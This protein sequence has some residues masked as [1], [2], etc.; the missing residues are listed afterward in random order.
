MAILGQLPTVNGL[1]ERPPRRELLGLDGKPLLKESG[2]FLLPP[3][4][5]FAAIY[6]SLSRTYWDLFEDSLRDSRQNA[7]AMRRDSFVRACL[8][9]RYLQLV[10]LSHHLESEDQKSRVQKPVT[11]ELSKI[12]G[13]TRRWRHFLWQLAEAIWFGRTGNQLKWG[14]LAI[15]GTQRLCVVDHRPVGESKINFDYDGTP[16]IRLHYQAFSELGLED[17]AKSKDLQI[18]NRS[19]VIKLRDPL[20]RDRFVI[21]KHTPEDPDF[22]EGEFAGQVHGLGLRGLCYWSLYLRDEMLG[23]AVNHLKKIGVG[24][25]LCFFYDESNDE[26]RAKAEAAAQDAGENFAI[27]MPRPRG[28]SKETAS[29][30][31]F[32]FSEAG[33]Q[34]LINVVSDYFERHVERLIIGQELSSKAESTGLGSGVATMQADTK[35]RILK[36]D[37]E[38]L[39]DCLTWEYVKVAQK[40]NFPNANWMTKFVF[41]VPDPQAGE[42][43]KAAGIAFQTGAEIKS[44]ELLAAAGFSRAEEDDDTLS[45]IKLL[46]AT[47]EIQMKAQLALA[48]AQGQMQM[49]QAQEAQASGLAPQPM[50]QQGA[51]PGAQQGE[52][53]GQEQGQP[54]EIPQGQEE[55]PQGEQKIPTGADVLAAIMEPEEENELILADG[56]SLPLDEDDEDSEEQ[57][58]GPQQMSTHGKSVTYAATHS[59]SGGT[60]IAGTFYPGGQYIPNAVL[61]KATPQEKAALAGKKAMTG[62]KVP[63]MPAHKPMHEIAEKR[64]QEAKPEPS[65]EVSPTAPESTQGADVYVPSVNSPVMA[66]HEFESIQGSDRWQR[67]NDQV[68][69]AV[70][71]L[72]EHYGNLPPKG[73]NSWYV[74][75][76]KAYQA[77]REVGI[78]V[79]DLGELATNDPKVL[80]AQ[81]FYVMDGYMGQRSRTLRDKAQKRDIS[82]LA[83]DSSKFLAKHA[84]KWINNPQAAR[85]ALA[86]S[87]F[88]GTP[89]LDNVV[90]PALGVNSQ[91]Q[92]SAKKDLAI[93]ASLATQEMISTAVKAAIESIPGIIKIFANRGVKTLQD[94]ELVF[95]YEGEENHSDLEIV[96]QILADSMYERLMA[97][98]VANHEAARIA[99][100]H[101]SRCAP[102]VLQMAMQKIEEENQGLTPEQILAH[103]RQVAIGVTGDAVVHHLKNGLPNDDMGGARHVALWMRDR[104]KNRLRRAGLGLSEVDL[105]EIASDE[106]MRLAPQIA[107]AV[108]V[109]TSIGYQGEFDESKH[110]RDHGKFATAIAHIAGASGSGKTTL[111]N[112]LQ[113][114]HKNIHV[115][116]LDDF[117][118]EASEHLYPGVPKKKY[119]DEM[120]NTLAGQRQ[121]MLDDFMANSDKPVVL[122]GH[123]TEGKHQLH[124]PAESKYLLDVDAK[125]S[126]MR[127]FKRSQTEKPE[128]RRKMSEL[129]LDEKEAQQDIDFL[130]K[131]GYKRMSPQ[132]IEDAISKHPSVSGESQ[133][134]SSINFQ[135]AEYLP[136]HAPCYLELG[137]VEYQAGE[138]IPAEAVERIIEGERKWLASLK[139]EA[140][141]KPEIKPV[142]LN[143]PV[144]LKA[145][146]Q[147]IRIGEY[148]FHPGMYIPPKYVA[149][150]DDS[151]K[152]L[153]GG[154]TYANGDANVGT[155]VE[156]L[157]NGMVKDPE[158]A[159]PLS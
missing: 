52:Q 21:H 4:R 136:S 37:A 108:G 98:G 42:K 91:S 18:V 61:A 117:D 155:G 112:K 114:K 107:S 74:A 138:F 124:I 150:M 95:T 119:T 92:P 30:E 48:Q 101:S 157:P 56:T 14:P 133:L 122:V 148:F 79:K 109:Q 141:E 110:P 86:K 39:A 89:I 57:V 70:M 85:K 126:A 76:G 90:G 45:Q 28:G 68:K 29:L 36:F 105:E 128:H 44:D 2:G 58:S 152:K 75:R 103:A 135:S 17:L 67:L 140:E 73:S 127:A 41:D 156:E 33:M 132:Q 60:T 71:E 158:G 63:E 111:G 113:E 96:E 134:E 31:F 35:W 131:A 146:A 139:Y 62:E 88:V 72:I 34:S 10:G 80:N 13:N 51:Q 27:T 142:Q 7:L 24:G 123:H 81:A 53:E 83:H 87:E 43:M 118:D 153:C 69:P 82:K 120:I 102:M 77:I 25:L 47:T 115:K 99:D 97:Q 84:Q 78:S 116:D 100:E 16:K 64:E 46:A 106:A 130:D 32:P 19:P 65:Q 50:A 12:I 125:T 93:G 8:Q 143:F 159:K 11:D 94:H 1:L 54:Q 23:W 38:N 6:S 5:T 20:W 15:N 9:E 145:P 129:P 3:E 151:M 40:W 104:I 59:P 55:S 22:F 49:E 66:P 147:G 26:S 149:M 121:W 137:G 154:E 144:G